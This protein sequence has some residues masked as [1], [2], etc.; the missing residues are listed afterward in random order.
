MANPPMAKPPNGNP[1]EQ[2][3]ASLSQLSQVDQMRAWQAHHKASAFDSLKQLWI[4]PVQSFMTWMMIAIAL[5]LPAALLIVVSY[6]KTL[7]GQWLSDPGITIYLKTP[8]SESTQLSVGERLQKLPG[9]TSVEYISPQQGLEELVRHG[10]FGDALSVLEENPLPPVY[11][12]KSVDGREESLRLLSEQVRAFAE[13]D[14][15]QLD[16]EWVQRLHHMVTM[17]ERVAILL[18]I[19][20]SLGVLLAVGNA[21][22]LMLESRRDEMAVIKL[23]GGTDAFMRRPLLYTGLWHGLTG[24]LLA[25]LLLMASSR[26]LSPVVQALLVSYGSEGVLRGP[27][28]LSLFQLLLVGGSLGILGA[29]LA[30]SRHIKTAYKI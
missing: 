2:R 8:L 26:W 14:K 21:T 18:G 30:V 19:F 4:S 10:G 28:F 25:W 17:V 5:A 29:W 16:L 6:V 24:G 7:G 13:V 22:R 1:T 9:A 12:L 15:V 20:L 11:L 27:D 3:G 23:V